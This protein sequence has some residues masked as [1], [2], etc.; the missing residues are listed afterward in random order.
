MSDVGICPTCGAKSKISDKGGVITYKAVQDEEA[1]KKVEQMKKAMLKYKNEVERL[2]K[3][4]K[5]LKEKL[6]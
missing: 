5:A 3:E 1:F 4:L 6:T 2:E